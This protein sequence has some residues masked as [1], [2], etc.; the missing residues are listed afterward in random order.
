VAKRRKNEDPFA[1][2]HKILQDLTGGVTE[3][4]DQFPAMVYRCANDPDW[5]MEK[6]SA[7]CLA[8]T[9]HPREDLLGNRR[10]SFGTLVHPEDADDLWERC[11]ASLDQRQQ[12]NN[13]YRIIA[14]NGAEKWVRDRAHGIYDDTGELL[15]IEGFIVDITQRKRDEEARLKN[16][17]RFRELFDASPDAVLME[18]LE[19]Y[20]LDANPEACSLHGR[21]REELIGLH[22]S[23]LVPAE[24]LDDAA[25]EFE[26][27]AR[28]EKAVVE[29][30]S[31]T[32]DGRAVPVELRSSRINFSGKPALLL[33]VRDITERKEYQSRLEYLARFDALTDLPN[34]VLFEDRLRQALARASRSGEQ[35]AVHYLDIDYF[36]GVND[37][38]GH[39]V[40]DELLKAVAERL[41]ALLRETDTVARLGGDEFAVLQVGVGSV[42]GVTALAMKLLAAFTRSFG[43]RGQ[44]MRMSTSIGVAVWEPDVEPNELME[45]ADRALYRAKELGRNTFH[46]HDEKLAEEVKT[47]V[48]IREDLDRALER[49]EFLLEYQPQIDLSSGRIVGCEA[50]VRW[51]H[52]SRGL[53]YPNGFIPI[54]EKTGLIVP[55]GAWILKEVCRQRKNWC[56]AGLPEVS[57]AVNLSA[58]Q[59]K[60]PSFARRIFDILDETGLDS[61]LLEMELTESVLMQR[62]QGV[63]DGIFQSHERGIKIAIDDFGTGYSSLQYLRQFPVHK[64]KIAMEFVQGIADSAED[65]SIV[66]SVI[67]LG[68]K[69]GLKVVAEGVETEQ[70]LYFLR[71]HDCDEAQGF[72]FSRPVAPEVFAEQLAPGPEQ[73]RP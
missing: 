18:D 41:A 10:V 71:E 61:G 25:R 27:L 72:L 45:Q 14:A 49:D 59:F 34:R 50:L 60:D 37:T 8:V 38:H 43:V 57:V 30:Y 36:K 3:L 48:T 12:C 54:S 33:H 42:A 64:L 16:D 52:P 23:E 56:N 22:F 68:H 1:D 15:A 26:Q 51:Q 40:G 13:E 32:K 63:Q 5:T 62:S 66:E 46:F 24:R 19:G 9:G 55:L 20:L 73:A 53:L 65:A 2:E 58:V 70:Q 67:S 31:L 11:Q 17:K 6:V 28:G 39:N 21:A 29:G 4:L 44:E 47:Y 69:L 7:G 35:I